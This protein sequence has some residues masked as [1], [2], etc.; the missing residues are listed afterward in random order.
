MVTIEIDEMEFNNLMN[1]YTNFYTTEENIA[2]Y[3]YLNS[4][5]SHE[6]NLHELLT[7]SCIE[8]YTKKEFDCKRLKGM[9]YTKHTAKNGLIIVEVHNY[10]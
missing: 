7:N 6:V 4:K 1:C 2:I 3:D 9:N 10:V 8:V 5:Y